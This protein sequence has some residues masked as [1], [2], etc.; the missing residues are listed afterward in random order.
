MRGAQWNVDGGAWQNSGTTVVGL[1]VGN[2][3]VSYKSVFGWDTPQS[4]TITINEDVTTETTGVYVEQTGSLKVTIT[5]QGAT[6]EGAAWN[7]D[8][9]LWK[10]SGETVSGLSVGEHEVNYRATFGYQHL[11]TATVNI[12]EG[13]TTEETGNYTKIAGNTLKVPS[14]YTSIQEAINAASTGDTV[15]LADGTYYGTGNKNLDFGGKAIKVTSENG[16]ENC[17]IDCESDGRGFYFHS[18][19]K[20]D[21]KLSGLTVKHGLVSN[22]GG[23]IYCADSSPMITECTITDNRAGGSIG[24]GGGIYCRGSSTITNCTITDNRA[25]GHDGG[26]YGGGIYCGASSTI[27]NCT[28]TDNRAWGEYVVG[29]SGYGGGIYCG[30]SSTITNCTITGNRATGHNGYGGGIY[31]GASST[32]TNCILFGDTPDEI[33]VSSG[34]LVTYSDIQGGYSG[35]GNINADPLFIGN[36]DY[37]LKGI[38]PCID[39]GTSNGAPNTDIEGNPRPQ[40]GGYD[41]GAYEYPGFP[42]AIPT[43][44]TIAISLINHQ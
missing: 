6:D 22:S 3:T 40:G 13:E 31:C 16:A 30:A 41:M 35:I 15:M 2:H 5:P 23:G 43:V 9:G 32:I 38:S 17:I 39:S 27:T 36:G 34:N 21:S 44:S 12:N 26:G 20:E 33:Y 1:T 37:H 11:S 25:S 7:V 18:G 4:E 29:S 42:T 19:E 14:E 28:I 10:E 8:G 24:Y